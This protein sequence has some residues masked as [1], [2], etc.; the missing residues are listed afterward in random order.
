MLELGLLPQPP[1]ELS[2]QDVSPEFISMLAQAQRAIG[3]NSIDRYVGSLGMVAQMKPEVLDN[4]DADKWASEYGD[5]LGV[6]ARLRVDPADVAALRTARAQTMAAK[7]QAAAMREQV[8]R[9]ATWLRRPPGRPTERTHGHPQPVQRL[10]VTKP[11]P[12]V[13]MAQCANPADSAVAVT[14]SDST[15]LTET[16][17]LYVGVEG[18]VAVTIGGANVTFVGVPS[19][20]IL[21]IRVTKVLSTGTTASSIVAL[22]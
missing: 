2:G 11:G 5:M 12:G 18:D 10:R 1:E 19:E 14:K 4:F 21:P 13:S 20:A 15:V 22:Y 6:P 3:T 9:P 16:R 7:E 17:G 8:R